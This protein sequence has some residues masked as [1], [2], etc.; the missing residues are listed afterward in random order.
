MEIYWLIVKLI[1]FMQEYQVVIF[2]V[3]ILMGLSL[4]V[5]AK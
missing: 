5:I 3:L 2:V 1:L 4:F